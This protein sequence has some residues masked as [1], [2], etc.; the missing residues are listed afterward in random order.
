[1]YYATSQTIVKHKESGMLFQPSAPS[2]LPPCCV[3]TESYGAIAEWGH[4]YGKHFLEALQV[5]TTLRNIAIGMMRLMGAPNIAAACRT[6]AAQPWTALAVIGIP[7][8][9]K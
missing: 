8:R 1:M 2:P 5:M 3:A 4:N 9:I 7:G 6:F